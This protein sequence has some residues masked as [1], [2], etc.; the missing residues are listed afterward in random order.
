MTT[1]DKINLVKKTKCKIA[2]ESFYGFYFYVTKK[3]VL[4]NSSN[5]FWIASK[6]TENNDVCWISSKNK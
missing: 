1:E 4:T 6:V 3:E 2:V 5:G